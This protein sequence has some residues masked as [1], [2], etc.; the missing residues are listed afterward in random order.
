MNV[1]QRDKPGA[2][3]DRRCLLTSSNQLNINGWSWIN[4]LD[5]ARHQNAKWGDAFLGLIRLVE[6]QTRW[7]SQPSSTETVLEAYG[8]PKKCI[9]PLICQPNQHLQTLNTSWKIGFT[10]ELFWIGLTR[11]WWHLINRWLGVLIVSPERGAKPC[12]PLSVTD[13]DCV[14]ILWS[15]WCDMCLCDALTKGL[16]HY[17]NVMLCHLETCFP[18]NNVN[19]GNTSLWSQHRLCLFQVR[20]PACAMIV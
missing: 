13:P 1:I 17:S 12:H 7:G 5:S 20:K 16:T 15:I 3:N 14:S 10:A 6:F 2:N 18:W 11:R 19:K 9:F 4:M 8:C